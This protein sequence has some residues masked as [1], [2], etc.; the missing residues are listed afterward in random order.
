[1]DEKIAA[2]IIGAIFGIITTYL[3]AVLK[4]RSDLRFEYDKD[5]RAKR[6]EHYL[7][8][9]RL[10]S[11]FPK[12]G[13]E[14]DVTLP[15]VRTLTIGF[16]DWYFKSGMFLSDRS[17]D[18]YFHFQEALAELLKDPAVDPTKA[19]DEGT[20]NRLRAMGSDLRSALVID[21]GTRKVSELGQQQRQ[22]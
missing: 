19:L 4:F 14:G 9:W 20:Y 17:R 8:L 21:V 18:A 2:A 13:R 16:R 22:N 6:I 3:G 7:E 11:L 5:L 10:T 15:N 1:M 12:Y